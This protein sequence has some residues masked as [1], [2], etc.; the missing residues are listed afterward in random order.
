MLFGP[1]QPDLVQPSPEERKLIEDARRRLE[2]QD[3]HFKDAVD[4]SGTFSWTGF[5]IALA[6]LL[7]LAAFAFGMLRLIS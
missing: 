1:T 7:L 4:G 2:A 3:S 6:I 5:A